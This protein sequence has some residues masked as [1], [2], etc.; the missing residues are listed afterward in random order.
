M[1]GARRILQ[2]ESNVTERWADSVLLAG[3][4]EAENAVVHLRHEAFTE[5]AAFES[6]GTTSNLL[7]A[8]SVAI[9]DVRRNLGATGTIPG[10]SIRRVALEWMDLADPEWHM[11]AVGDESLHWMFDDRDARR[12]YL[13]PPVNG[14]VELVYSKT[15]P[16]V[17]A[18]DDINLADVYA[19]ALRA[20]V[21]YYAFAQDTDNSASKALATEWY[22]HFV[23]LVTGK[24]MAEEAL[25]RGKHR[26][27]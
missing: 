9:I 25:D 18:V 20:Y 17:A 3:L 11:A 2:D 22:Q 26:A 7:P 5:V 19:P 12:F 6:A 16:A 4:N 21:V 13:W 14:V 27:P 24:K 23:Y 1:D 15:P 8:D 10:R